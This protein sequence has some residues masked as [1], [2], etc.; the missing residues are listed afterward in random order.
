MVFALG[1]DEQAEA[2]D[3][4]TSSILG[5]LVLGYTGRRSSP[6]QKDGRLKYTNE[7]NI[8][9]AGLAVSVSCKLESY[10]LKTSEP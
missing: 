9:P 4:G 3:E 10:Q 6:E 1:P 5:C 8:K 2:R 7:S